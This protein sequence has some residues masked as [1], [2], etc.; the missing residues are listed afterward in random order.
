MATKKKEYFNNELTFIYRWA[1][2]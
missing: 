2:F 1:K